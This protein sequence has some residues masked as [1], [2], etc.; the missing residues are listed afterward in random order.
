MTLQIKAVKGHELGD[1]ALALDIGEKLKSAYPGWGWEVKVDDEPTGGVIT[2]ISRIF[3]GFNPLRNPFGLTMHLTTAYSDPSR[4]K[5]L[6]RA[7]QFLEFCG[8]PQRYNGED[9]DLTE[10]GNNYQLYYKRLNYGY[11]PND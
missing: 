3:E 11:G 5:I 8:L 6:K 10:F 7:G 2:V 1:Y 9:L 4:K